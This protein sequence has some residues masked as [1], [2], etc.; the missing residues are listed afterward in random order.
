MKSH[1]GLIAHFQML[2]PNFNVGH[3]NVLTHSHTLS[4]FI[5][6]PLDVQY[7]Y[8]TFLKMNDLI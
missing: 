1:P 3:G 5:L 8:I 7:Y 2:I 4:V 6:P